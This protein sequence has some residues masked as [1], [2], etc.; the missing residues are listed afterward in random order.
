ML[1]FVSI[2]LPLP[3]TQIELS[4][5]LSAGAK[6]TD[7]IGFLRLRDDVDA[8]KFSL[9]ACSWQ[10]KLTTPSPPHASYQQGK[11][12]LSVVFGKTETNAW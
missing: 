10:L 11:I 4:V 1:F 6:A 8:T 2:H 3:H 7:M 12:G 9:L 5:L